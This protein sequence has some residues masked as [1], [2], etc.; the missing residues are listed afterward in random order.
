MNCYAFIVPTGKFWLMICDWKGELIRERE[1]QSPV[2]RWFLFSRS[3]R[4]SFQIRRVRDLEPLGTCINNCGKRTGTVDTASLNN[5][6][7]ER[8]KVK[9]RLRLETLITN[10]QLLEKHNIYPYPEGPPESKTSH[11]YEYIPNEMVPNLKLMWY[12]IF[13]FCDQ[14]FWSMFQ[15]YL[16]YSTYLSFCFV[17]LLGSNGKTILLP[18]Q[19]K[20]L[21]TLS[22]G[23]NIYGLYYIITY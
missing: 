16:L 6:L 2:M 14:K 15:I 5:Y 19:G 18:R 11:A 4:P 17:F 8:L 12:N 21:T 9:C 22:N 20:S 10:T 1:T 23:I 13:R 7:R 3:L